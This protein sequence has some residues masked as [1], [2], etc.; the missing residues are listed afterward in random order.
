MVKVVCAFLF[1]TFSHAIV[2]KEKV[3][4]VINGGIETLEKAIYWV[5]V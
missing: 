4:F 2:N 1:I 5:R 3:R